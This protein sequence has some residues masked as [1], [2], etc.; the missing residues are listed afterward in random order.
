M[1]ELLDVNTEATETATE[2]TKTTTETSSWHGD[3]YG[4]LVKAKGWNGAD[5]AL[6]GYSQ[7]EKLKGMPEFSKYMAD[8]PDGTDGYKYEF[9]G[10]GESPISK[11]LLDGFFQFAHEKHMPNSFINDVIDFQLDAIKAGDEMFATQQTERKTEN[12]ESMKKKWQADY[13]STITKIDT[14]AEKLGVKAYFETMG[15]DKEPEIVNM[16]LTIANSDS[17]DTLN[18][19]GDAPPAATTLQDKL[20]E[21]MKSEAYLQR[22]HPDHKK[23]MAEFMELNMTIANTGQQKAPQ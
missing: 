5:D 17:E 19:D 4:E 15:I 16:L 23:V 12:I 6:N 1:T 13:D 10:D 14:V 7:L 2:A 18:T 9:K 20:T 8:I 11:E 22:F 21:I 3:E